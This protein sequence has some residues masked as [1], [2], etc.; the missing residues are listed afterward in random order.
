MKLHL[1]FC[2]VWGQIFVFTVTYI[3]ILCLCF[4]LSVT[5]YSWRSKTTHPSWSS[6]SHEVIRLGLSTGA[7]PTDPA[8]LLEAASLSE[9]EVNQLGK[10]SW[11]V[12]ARNPP[13]SASSGLGSQ[14]ICLHECWAFKRR[15]LCLHGKYFL[16]RPSPNLSEMLL[17]SLYGL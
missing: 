4:C 9:L 12:S 17:G 8:F 5:Q 13:A 10:T 1:C 15:P 14:P 7:L 6:P 16:H 2:L 3:F 11:S